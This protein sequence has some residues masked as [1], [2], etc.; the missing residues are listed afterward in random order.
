M[1]A[2]DAPPS[3]LRS[4]L[5]K[6]AKFN[7]GLA[8][9][10]LAAWYGAA[11]MPIGSRIDADSRSLDVQR[12]RLALAAEIQS[13]RREVQSYDARLPK[14][15]ADGNS[16]VHFVM[17]GVRETSLKL[18]AL[19]PRP[20]TTVGPYP[21]AVIAATVEGTYP[22]VERFLGW[23]ETAPR[24]LRIDMMRVTAKEDKDAGK[25]AEGEAP[26]PT[27]TE[28]KLLIIGVES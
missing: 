20:P 12:E 24:V 15:E 13:L 18:V 21:A 14:K 10:A 28:M 3:R 8:V 22:Q 19:E 1:I 9:L 5:E 23:L 16:W 25:R 7:V 2:P 6:P 27:V 26:P 4:L 11:Y 17:T